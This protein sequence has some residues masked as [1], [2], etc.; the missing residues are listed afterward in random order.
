MVLAEM[1]MLTSE[2]LHQR[3]STPALL[4][5]RLT[6]TRKSTTVKRHGQSLNVNK[7]R[8]AAILSPLCARHPSQTSSTIPS[9]QIGLLQ[10]TCRQTTVCP[11]TSCLRTSTSSRWKP[12]RKFRKL[13]MLQALLLKRDILNPLQK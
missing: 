7:M 2:I 9:W 10:K 5:L 12:S 4:M 13:G 3:L 1:M 8:F 6:K 11:R